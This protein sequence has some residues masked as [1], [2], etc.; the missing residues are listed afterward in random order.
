MNEDLVVVFTA[1][2][3]LEE[4]QVRS[5]LAA[6]DIPTSTRGEAL[7]H[8]HGLTL[9]GLGAVE[10]MVAAEHEATARLLLDQAERGE[11]TL[12]DSIES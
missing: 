3:E 2:G 9:D 1:Q 6:H 10:I 7:R 12:D 11:L 4:T 8:T 5:F